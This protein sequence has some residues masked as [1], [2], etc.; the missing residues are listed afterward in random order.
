[1]DCGEWKRGGATTRP[2]QIL[3][4]L[5]HQALTTPLK[6]PSSGGLRTLTAQNSVRPSSCASSRRAHRS[7]RAPESFADLICNL[8]TSGKCQINPRCAPLILRPSAPSDRPG[9]DLLHP[10]PR[11]H[12]FWLLEDPHAI[13]PPNILALDI[14]ISAPVTHTIPS[15]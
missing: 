14:C 5:L 12:G 3:R 11:C 8:S 6:V 1:M 4:R 10:G 7:I 9:R 15:I 13:L 2:S